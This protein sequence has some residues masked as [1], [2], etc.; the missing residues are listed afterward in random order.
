MFG[1]SRLGHPGSQ[2]ARR[3]QERTEHRQQNASWIPISRVAPVAP[4]R[5]KRGTMIGCTH[6][7]ARIAPGAAGELLTAAA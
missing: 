4:E 5:H 3:E 2:Q 1:D 6:P 7:N